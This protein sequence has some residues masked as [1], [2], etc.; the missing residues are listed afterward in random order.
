MADEVN[1]SNPFDVHTIR[2]LVVLMSRHDLSE[3]DLRHGS[4]RICLR[5]GAQVQ[6]VSTPVTMTALPALPG[7]MVSPVPA[8]KAEEATAPS[9][10]YHV[11]KSTLVGTFYQR[12]S[13]DAEP[14]VRVGSRVTPTTVVGV[15]EAMKIYTDVQA[16]CSGVIAEIL[17]DNAKPVDYNTPLFRV[18][19]EG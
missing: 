11:I 2:Q 18:D 6:T 16:E 12:P 1:E 7:P 17:V 13:P 4:T 8:P 14:Y 19:P 3:I 15:I 10:T 5:R 9:K